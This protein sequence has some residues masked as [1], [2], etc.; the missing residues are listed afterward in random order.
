VAAGAA[1]GAAITSGEAGSAGG[2]AP[3]GLSGVFGISGV[4]GVGLDMGG[5]SGIGGGAACAKSATGTDA[6]SNAKIIRRGFDWTLMINSI[7]DE[8]EYW[9]PFP[10]HP[11]GSQDS[12]NLNARGTAKPPF[13]T[14]HPG[15]LSENRVLRRGTIAYGIE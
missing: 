1:A 3:S 5:M 6:S 11:C 12:S 7:I 9:G 10:R 13:A 14:Q 8:P 4:V 15:F 2:V